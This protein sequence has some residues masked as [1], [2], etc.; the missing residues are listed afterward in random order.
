MATVSDRGKIQ[1]NLYILEPFLML[2]RLTVW[3]KN[4]LK[5]QSVAGPRGPDPLPSPGRVSVAGAGAAQRGLG[6]TL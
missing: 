4:F 5:Q 6:K 3:P 1:T 2:Q